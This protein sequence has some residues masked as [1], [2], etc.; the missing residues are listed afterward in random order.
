[1]GRELVQQG[2][3]AEAEAYLR[4]AVEAARQGFGDDDPHMASACNNLAEFYRLRRRYEEAE[5]LYKQ[6]GRRVVVV[7][8]VC[9]CVGVG[10][11]GGSAE[12]GG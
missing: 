5:P 9:V 11:G 1:M 8:V 2:R 12:G 3:H 4:R 10:G 6:A 7:V